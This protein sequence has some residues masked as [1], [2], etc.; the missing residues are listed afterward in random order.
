MRGCGTL[1]APGPGPVI[2]T[3][4]SESPTHADLCQRVER[5]T[6]GIFHAKASQSIPGGPA[7]R[8]GTRGPPCV[9]PHVA[10]GPAL[11]L[12]FLG[13]SAGFSRPGACLLLRLRPFRPWLRQRLYLCPRQRG[14]SLPSG[15]LGTGPGGAA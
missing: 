8:K 1:A 10:L 7:A 15:G 12:I 11:S 14:I 9:C 3:L 13:P 6:H 4:V 5:R 2:L